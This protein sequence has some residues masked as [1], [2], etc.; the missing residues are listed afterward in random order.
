MTATLAENARRVELFDCFPGGNDTYLCIAGNQERS[1]YPRLDRIIRTRYPHFEQ[2]GFLEP[3]QAPAVIRL[4]MAG[5]EFCGNAARSLGAW[6]AE[7]YL[8]GGQKYSHI[9]RYAAVTGSH[10][11]LQFP[12][13]V[14]GA[15]R[16]LSVTCKPVAEGVW[17]EVEMP[18]QE[19]LSLT[20]HEIPLGGRKVSVHKVELEGIVHVLCQGSSM[21]RCPDTASQSDFFHALEGAL[22]LENEPAIGLIRYE[23]DQG[24]DGSWKIDPIVFVR[25][26][27]SLVYESACASGSLA[28]AILLASRC[29]DVLVEP[30]GSESRV[31]RHTLVRHTFAIV[32]P[33]LTAIDCTL[34]TDADGLIRQ[35]YIS[36]VV[37]TRERLTIDLDH[38]LPPQAVRRAF[39]PWFRRL[40]RAVIQ[41]LRSVGRSRSP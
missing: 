7:Q 11:S 6:V 28:A 18:I 2:G 32:Q 5:G 8:S 34:L 14:S 30:R 23:E 36:G 20:R 29:G 1:S 35:A 3:C 9:V 37:Q 21:P 26:T 22:H 25:A 41:W 4:E 33:S 24:H 40:F 19:R 13:E 38:A 16:C 10:H 12:I 17:V 27:G 31:P 39:S 15:S